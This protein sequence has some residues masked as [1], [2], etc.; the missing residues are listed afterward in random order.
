[1]KLEFVDEQEI[2]RLFKESGYLERVN[3][4][5]LTTKVTYDQKAHPDSKQPEGTR[6]Q[7]VSYLDGDTE[8]AVVHQFV[9]PGGALGASGKPD[10][11]QVL[12][13]DTVHMLFPK[14]RGS[15]RIGRLRR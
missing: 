13:G 14:P 6:S 15:W 3:A 12:V 11:K 4:G 9:E 5:E 8:V 1:M 2:R 10:P 7:R